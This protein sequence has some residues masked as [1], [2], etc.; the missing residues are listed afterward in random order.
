[1]HSCKG[2][3]KNITGCSMN[4][5]H[6][7]IMII[8]LFPVVWMCSDLCFSQQKM[9]QYT[10][11]FQ[12][13]N[14]IY[15][16]YFDFRNNSPI[17]VSRIISDYNKTSNEFFEKILSKNTLTYLDT[18]GKQQTVNTNDVWGYCASDVVYINYG[19]DFNRIT[20]IGSIC[21][22]V[23][24]VPMRIG[25]ADPFYN[26]PFYNSQQ[27]TYVTQQYVI[28]TKTGRVLEFNVANMESLLSRDEELYKEFI[29]LKK[30]KKRDS[31][32]LYLRKYNEKH[33]IYFPI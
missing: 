29:I 28:D 8:S 27:Y 12:F 11:D 10:R 24:S 15:L 3:E 31:I 22:F 32:F 17:D 7:F 14:G 9:V 30:K 26:D 21:H 18:S 1:M 33:P 13:K 20:I 25:I 23:A 2:V 6:L 5:N 16:S 19:T 4:K